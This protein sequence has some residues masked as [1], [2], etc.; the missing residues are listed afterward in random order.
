M[1]TNNHYNRQNG[2]IL[3]HEK[4]FLL[5]IDDVPSDLQTMGNDDKFIEPIVD[6]GLHTVFN[7]D[8]S[9]DELNIDANNA[10]QYLLK[11]ILIPN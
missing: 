5:R 11:L 2:V 3:N 9:I 8:S 10:Y 6:E 1:I 4:L 7:F